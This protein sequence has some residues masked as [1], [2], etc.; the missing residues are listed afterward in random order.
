MQPRLEVSMEDICGRSLIEI[1]RQIS[2]WYVRR[3]L[4]EVVISLLI[5]PAGGSL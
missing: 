1:S 3:L 4:S 2:C 5:Y